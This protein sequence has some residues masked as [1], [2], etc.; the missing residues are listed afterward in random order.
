MVTLSSHNEIILWSC[1]TWECLQ[2]LKFIRRDIGINSMKLAVDETGKYIFLSDIDNNVC[3]YLI[4]D[5]IH[6][7]IC[8]YDDQSV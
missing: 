3:C 8:L 1:E 6:F 4:L 5:Y 2:K 7:I